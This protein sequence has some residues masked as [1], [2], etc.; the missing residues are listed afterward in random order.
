MPIASGRPLVL[1]Q[2]GAHRRCEGGQHRRVGRGHGVRGIAP[3]DEPEHPTRKVLDAV[4]DY[5][6]G[7]LG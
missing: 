5:F 3:V 1:A 4:M 6:D 2:A 7:Q